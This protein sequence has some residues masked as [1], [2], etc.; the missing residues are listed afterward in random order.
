MHGHRNDSIVY[1]EIVYTHAEHCKLAGENARVEKE[2]YR[3]KLC[4]VFKLCI[5]FCLAF[6]T[7]MHFVSAAIL[8]STATY[9]KMHIAKCAHAPALA[10]VLANIQ[11]TDNKSIQL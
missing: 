4:A 11:M 5:P 8:A 6:I 3:E 2:K 1:W 7:S 9:D 10:P